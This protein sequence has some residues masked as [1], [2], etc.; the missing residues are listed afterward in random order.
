MEKKNQNEIQKGTSKEKIRREKLYPPKSFP[1]KK[2]E[3]NNGREA[4]M[5]YNNR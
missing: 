3:I 4:K 5:V 2:I 1:V